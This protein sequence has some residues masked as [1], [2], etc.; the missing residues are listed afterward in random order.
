NP[1][2]QNGNGINGEDPGDAVTFRL[3]VNST[4]NGRFVTGLYHDLLSRPADTDG[5]LAFLASPD[6][7]RFQ[8]LPASALNIVTSAEARPGATRSTT[9]PPTPDSTRGCCAARREQPS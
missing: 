2:D 8:S 7:A 5:F 1:M 3:A 4:D 9:R 6:T